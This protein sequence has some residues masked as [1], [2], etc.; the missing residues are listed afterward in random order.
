MH[1]SVAEVF[2]TAYAMH[3]IFITKVWANSWKNTTSSLHQDTI[4]FAILDLAHHLFLIFS[5]QK[6]HHR[7]SDAGIDHIEAVHHV[8]ILPTFGSVSARQATSWA[9]RARGPRPQ[10]RLAMTQELLSEPYHGTSH[11]AGGYGRPDPVDCSKLVN[12]VS[13]S[14]TG[15]ARVCR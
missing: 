11:P 4:S 8:G 6:N 2:W 13:V 9:S 14:E 12:Y 7:E 5:P 15:P 3:P 10:S 1:T